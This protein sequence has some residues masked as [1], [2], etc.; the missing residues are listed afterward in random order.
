MFKREISRKLNVSR[1]TVGRV[2]RKGVQTEKRKPEKPDKDLELI[3]QLFQNC[4]GN[5][6]RVQEL[7]EQ[8][9]ARPMAYSTL[10]KVVREAHLRPPKPRAGKYTFGPGEEMQHDT[11]PHRVRIGEKTVTAMC[12]PGLGL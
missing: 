10:T 3:R 12:G 1:K 4:K 8:Q 11:S 6:V 7:M 2:L 9:Y 5:V